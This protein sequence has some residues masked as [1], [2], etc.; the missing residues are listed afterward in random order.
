MQ[1]SPLPVGLREYSVLVRPPHSYWNRIISAPDIFED[2]PYKITLDPIE[3][4]HPDFPKVARNGWGDDLVDL[5]A[6][7]EFS[8]KGAKVAIIGSGVDTEHPHLGHGPE[9]D[10][11]PLLPSFVAR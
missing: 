6:P 11:A 9:V 1:L 7:P 3:K 2:Q 5:T 8:G 10:I 4:S